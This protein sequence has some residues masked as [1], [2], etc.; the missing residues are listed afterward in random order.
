M[1]THTGEDPEI[2]QIRTQNQAKQ[3]DWS[4][5]TRKK[6]PIK[7]IQTTTR[8]WLSLWAHPC[9]YPHMLYSF[10]PNK[11]IMYFTTF[12]LYVEIHFYA[13]NGP[14]RCHWPLVPGGLAARIWCSHCCDPTSISGWEPKPSF[15]PLLAKA[16]W[17]HFMGPKPGIGYLSRNC[18]Q[19]D[20]WRLAN[21]WPER[22]WLYPELC[23]TAHHLPAAAL[24]ACLLVK[25]GYNGI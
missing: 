13:T 23:K 24:S 15:K 17:D 20:E 18:Q 19:V 2:Y 16:T 12:R 9:V 14:G 8:A 6:C 21:W 3:D 22:V 11:H 4:K 1:R 10:L 25:K 7:V 5:E